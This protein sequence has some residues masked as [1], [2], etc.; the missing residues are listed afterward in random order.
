MACPCHGETSSLEPRASLSSSVPPAIPGQSC[1]H[2]RLVSRRPQPLT[3]DELRSAGLGHTVH[4]RRV[5]ARC[6][7][8]PTGRR[9]TR[10]TQ[11]S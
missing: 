9:E 8:G 5:A 7:V 6:T 1:P 10:W 3:V 2:P 11:S 4:L